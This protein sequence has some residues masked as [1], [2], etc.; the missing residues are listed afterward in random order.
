MKRVPMYPGSV[1]GQARMFFGLFLAFIVLLLIISQFDG[2]D[3]IIQDGKVTSKSSKFISEAVDFQ[4]K[5]LLVATQF[6]QLNKF[7]QL[8]S[9]PGCKDAKTDITTSVFYYYGVDFTRILFFPKMK[10]Y[11]VPP[12]GDLMVLESSPGNSSQEVKFY[13]TDCLPNHVLETFA[14]DDLKEALISNEKAA[15]KSQSDLFKKRKGEAV[16]KKYLEYITDF[17]DAREWIRIDNPNKN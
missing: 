12:L 11:Y 2:C 6:T 15:L 3:G 10:K 13:G 17:Y 7:T 5:E 8:R 16:V 9:S 1:K 14:D 4:D